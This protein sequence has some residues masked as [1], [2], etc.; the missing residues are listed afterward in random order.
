MCLTCV[1][2][3]TAPSI[4]LSSNQLLT[5]LLSVSIT[6]EASAVRNNLIS[7]RYGSFTSWLD[8]FSSLSPPP[9]LQVRCLEWPTWPSADFQTALDPPSLAAMQWP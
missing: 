2:P 1:L 9:V 6:C 8:P 7:K 5:L 4:A 3:L